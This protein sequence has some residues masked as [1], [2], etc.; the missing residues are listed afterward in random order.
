MTTHKSNFSIFCL[1]SPEIMRHQAKTNWG[2]HLIRAVLA[3]LYQ[4]LHI[5]YRVFWDIR[6]GRKIYG[7]IGYHTK[8]LHGFQ[9]NKQ[10]INPL[11]YVVWIISGQEEQLE[12]CSNFTCPPPPLVCLLCARSDLISSLHRQ[13]GW[14]FAYSIE[15]CVGLPYDPLL[16][17]I[18]F[19]PVS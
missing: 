7:F 19:I 16:S 14:F 15:N 1:V 3:I 10:K 17:R 2:G 13:E 18:F 6:Q 5:F 12:L 11:V 9:L 4:V 8:A